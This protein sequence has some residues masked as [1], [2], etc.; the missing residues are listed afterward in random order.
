MSKNSLFKHPIG[1]SVDI[2]LVNFH[3]LFKLATERINSNPVHISLHAKNFFSRSSCIRIANWT[4]QNWPLLVISKR[5]DAARPLDHKRTKISREG[6]G[7]LL[8]C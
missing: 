7:S 5:D 2:T 8:K 3:G 4:V 6:V 1:R